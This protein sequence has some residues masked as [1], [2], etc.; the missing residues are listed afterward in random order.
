MQEENK[1]LEVEE[2]LDLEEMRKKLQAQQPWFRLMVP[3]AGK[4]IVWLA[5]PEAEV[6]RNYL[7]ENIQLSFER[8]LAGQTDKQGNDLTDIYRGYIKA[9]R[10]IF[11]MKMALEAQVAQDKKQVEES[12]KKKKQF[13]EGA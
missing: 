7:A 3:Q 2:G 9:L 11:N 4:L 10:E 6:F 12:E 1:V 8:L 5:Q 13:E